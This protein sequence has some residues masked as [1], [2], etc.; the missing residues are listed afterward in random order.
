MGYQKDKCVGVS[1]LVAAAAVRPTAQ[2]GLPA[3]DDA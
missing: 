1:L 2:G 3:K